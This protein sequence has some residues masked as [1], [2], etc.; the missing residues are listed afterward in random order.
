ML[1]PSYVVF[2][3]EAYRIN[4]KKEKKNNELTFNL[5]LILVNFGNK[6]VFLSYGPVHQII[7]KDLSLRLVKEFEYT[8]S[9]AKMLLLGGIQTLEAALITMA[10]INNGIVY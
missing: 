4:K 3:T 10:A 5:P 1:V 8:I 6:S 7:A 9:T 2:L